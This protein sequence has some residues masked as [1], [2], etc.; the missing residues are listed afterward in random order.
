[1]KIK[2]ILTLF[3]IGTMTGMVTVVSAASI[4]AG[5]KKAEVCA[6][7]HGEGGKGA[8]PIFPKLAGQNA[9]YLS[10]QLRYFKDQVRNIPA[11]N[12]VASTL[13]DEDI[14]DLSAYFSAHSPGPEEGEAPPEG[15]KIY[16]SGMAEKKVPACSACHGPQGQ[17]N[18]PAGFPLLKGQYPAYTVKALTDFASGERGEEKSPMRTIAQRMTEDEMKAVAAYIGSLK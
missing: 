2:T 9:K 11:M 17:G 12:A 3:T 14:A 15:V 8:N 7:C 13:S 4:Q 10:R 6:G 1:M 16:L 5:K 18:A